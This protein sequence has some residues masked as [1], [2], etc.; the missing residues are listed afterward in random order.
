MSIQDVPCGRTDINLGRDPGRDLIGKL[1]ESAS[2]HSHG[3][4]KSTFL[5]SGFLEEK[6]WKKRDEFCLIH[7]VI[8][9]WVGGLW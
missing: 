6:S 8:D 7:G 3:V 9:S 1:L 4:L 2:T 5:A